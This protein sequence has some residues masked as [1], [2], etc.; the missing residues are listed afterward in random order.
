MVKSA[1]F[2]EPVTNFQQARIIHHCIS[3]KKKLFKTN[4][5]VWFNKMCRFHHLTVKYIHIKA[6]GNNV[7]RTHT[8]AR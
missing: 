3:T 8:H 6:N 2:I 1:H 7:K 4:A 5:V